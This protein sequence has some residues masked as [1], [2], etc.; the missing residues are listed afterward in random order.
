MV[1]SESL[2]HFKQLACVA[3][4]SVYS[5]WVVRNFEKARDSF[6]IGGETGSKMQRSLAFIVSLVGFDARLDEKT[7]HASRPVPSD[8]HVQ[9]IVVIVRNCSQVRTA[10]RQGS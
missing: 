6:R 10:G 5:A 8:R 7:D 4:Q 9:R 2:I 1:P 3:P